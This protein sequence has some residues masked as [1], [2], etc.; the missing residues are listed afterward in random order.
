MNSD[1]CADC[2]RPLSWI[3][4]SF[5][6]PFD[7]VCG[8]CIRARRAADPISAAVDS[9]Q[10]IEADP[11]LLEAVQTVCAASGCAW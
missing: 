9:I 3:E 6:R 1:H 4:I 8:R 2:G 10:E 11:Q 7:P 5:G